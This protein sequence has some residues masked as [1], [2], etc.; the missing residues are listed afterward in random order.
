MATLTDQLS[1]DMSLK[2][3]RQA[4]SPST[5]VATALN[6]LSKGIDVV[7]GAIRQRQR[8]KA[9]RADDEYQ[10][11]ERARKEEARKMPYLAEL[12]YREAEVDAQ[13]RLV[14]PTIAV[15]SS[16]V[17]FD[18][19]LAGK[20]V[21]DTTA[22]PFTGQAAADASRA[23]SDLN[24][25]Q[26]AVTQ[27]R[28]PAIS[29]NSALNKR[30]LDLINKYP[31][32][33]ET[34][35]KYLNDNGLNPSLARTA[36]DEQ[37]GHDNIR[38]HD[39]DWGNKMYDAGT[40][41]LAPELI[42]NM[43]REQIIAQGAA[44]TNTQFKLDQATKQAELALKNQSLSDAQRKAAEEDRDDSI[45]QVTVNEAWNN[46]GPIMTALQKSVVAISKLPIGQ[47]QAAFEQLAPQY[48]QW[49]QNYKAKAL[50]QA[51]ASGMTDPAKLT[52]LGTTIDVM[53]ERGRSLWSGD[54]AV[55]AS[56]RR[57]LD[58]VTNQ[59]KLDVAQSMP[60]FFALQNMGMK[61]DE[62]AGYTE[63]LAGNTELQT[64]LA[65]EMK[66]FTAEF[67]RKSASTRLMEIVSILKGQ[68]GLQDFDPAEA[69]KMMP[70]LFKTSDNYVN[71][72]GTGR[73]DV[74][75]D[76]MLNALGEVITA[77]RTVSP[78]TASTSSIKFATAGVA[79]NAVRTAL[80][81][82]LKD[83]VLNDQAEATIT[84]SRAASAQILLAMKNPK[85][86]ASYDTKFWKVTIDRE[87]GRAKAVP[88]GA[89]P[90]TVVGAGPYA[91]GVRTTETVP[92]KPPAEL[93]KWADYYN[94]N[95]TNISDMNSFD[96]NG[97]K[98]A[99]PL[100]VA[101]YYSLGVVPKALQVEK[102]KAANPQKEID[103]ILGTIQ[104]AFEGVPDMNTPINLKERNPYDVVFGH[105]QY[106]K[107]DKP[108]TSMTL[109][110]ATDFGD[111]VLKPATRAA[112]IGKIDGKV[113]GTSAIGA[114][115]IVGSTMRK[116][117]PEVFGKNWRDV[118]MTPENQ[119]K[120]GRY[121]FE[122]NKEGNLQKT[123]EGLPDRRPGAYADMSW[124]Q[125]KRIIQRYESA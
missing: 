74:S 5:G 56:N 91:G 78:A 7:D 48:D 73:G 103:N 119:D 123:W 21:F 69:R 76:T 6:A 44:V 90:I 24:N 60:V 19:D 75:G 33:T 89:K 30:F 85:T 83:P 14:D 23:V 84:G 20:Q 94:V 106:G 55:A 59:L 125:V 2:P 52:A 49:A 31:E 57:A 97:I 16:P 92:T 99:T 67:G 35:R 79:S 98:G 47:Q 105:G 93:Q 46:S 117:A 40:A 3:V 88:T 12:A 82:A 27:K 22:S 122:K 62:I 38:E 63:A 36:L 107:P 124:D 29:F 101:K 118:P 64:A 80:K 112:G 68:K 77:A 4:P 120:L 28:M 95:L 96:P 121:L 39:E 9:Q 1:T 41:S 61:P 34:I 113:V 71:M 10:A 13:G 51:S 111:S 17:A 53:V 86:L 11:K 110:E 70:T 37:S 72:Y 25:V 18:G 26:L 114:Y 42:A 15:P 54:M 8:D 87:T 50:A 43:S 81:K 115:Q 32:Q 65:K 116:V 66:G 104:D 109:G 58:S 102:Q 100:E 45:N 108:L